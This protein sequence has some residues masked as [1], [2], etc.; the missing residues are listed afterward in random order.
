MN[1]LH[2]RHGA[3]SSSAT[4]SRK[5][6]ECLR[7]RRD[8]GLSMLSVG[9]AAAED[10][11]QRLSW[12][13]DGFTQERSHWQKW[14]FPA[15]TASTVSLCFQMWWQKCRKKSRMPN[16]GWNLRRGSEKGK[17]CSERLLMP[18]GDPWYWFV[19]FNWETQAGE[20][21]LAQNSSII[22]WAGHDSPI[23]SFTHACPLLLAS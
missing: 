17:A 4:D 9:G 7:L 23:N 11:S 13:C 8:F 19:R 2:T 20:T 1:L 5:V 14:R 22:Y 18:D 6:K 15:A 21:N 16:L 12:T 10:P 3:A